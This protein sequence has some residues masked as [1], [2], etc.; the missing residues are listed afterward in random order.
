MDS[1]RIAFCYLDRLTWLRATLARLKLP[2][3]ILDHDTKRSIQ[4][5]TKVN[6]NP[7]RAE[8]IQGLQES[9]HQKSNFPWF[10]VK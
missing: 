1:A 6:G 8:T 5:E 7:N 3:F 9:F 2:L 4:T 10:P